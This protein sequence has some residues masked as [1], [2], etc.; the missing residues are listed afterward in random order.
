MK[1]TALA[2]AA[3]AMVASMV[4]AQGD[5]VAC[6]LC[7]Q[8]AIKALPACANVQPT[9]GSVSTAYAACLCSSLSGSWAD[10]CTAQ[11]GSAAV[12]TLKSSYSTLIQAAGLVCTGTQGWAGL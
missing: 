10:A 12:S 4:S 7:L 5:A 11:C 6:T 9:A 8:N 2:V 1:F 3:I